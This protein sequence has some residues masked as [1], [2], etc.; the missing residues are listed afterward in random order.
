MQ[1]TL[2][3]KSVTKVIGLESVDSTQ[4]LAKEL[5]LSGEPEGTLVLACCQTAGRGRYDR[6][7]SSEEGGV[8]FTLILRPKNKPA[9]CNASLSVRTGEALAQTLNRLFDIK[10]K[11]KLPNDVLAWDAKN[12]QWKKICG[13]LIET[14]ATSDNNQW[15]LVGVGV[16][17]N[18]CLPRALQKTAVSVKQLIRQEVSKELFLEELLNDFWKQ[19][20][21]WLASVK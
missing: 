13:V 5:A 9:A 11:V 7:F 3:V 18:N 2:T 8:Y 15:M 16:N 6:A 12:R 17:L 4:T 19:Y 14:S 20:A 21:Y 10:T 1:D